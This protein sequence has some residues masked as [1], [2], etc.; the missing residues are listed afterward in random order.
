MGQREAQVSIRT[1]RRL[2]NLRVPS[3]LTGPGR[4]NDGSLPP[5]SC[6]KTLSARGPRLLGR[7][8]GASPA[9]AAAGALEDLARFH[10]RFAGPRRALGALHRGWSVPRVLLARILTAT[11]P[12]PRRPRRARRRAPPRCTWPPVSS[13]SSTTPC[14]WT[15]CGTPGT[16]DRTS[17]A[18]RTSATSSSTARASGSS[19]GA[20]LS[21]HAVAR[22]QLLPDDGRRSRR[23]QAVGGGAAAALPRRLAAAVAPTSRSTRRGRSIA[24]KPATRSSRPSSRSCLRA[25]PATGEPSA[26]RC[27]RA[28]SSRSRIEVVEAMRAVLR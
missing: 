4:R 15:S 24:C 8:R 25:W 17:T 23:A 12:T 27:G 6:S 1:W 28:R 9:D 10:G 13:M 19:T 16:S 18:T 2:S 21:E 3:L 26:S 20:C 5:C 14:L 22:C 11:Q 7:L